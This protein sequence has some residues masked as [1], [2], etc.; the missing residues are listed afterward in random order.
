MILLRITLGSSG[1]RRF[2]KVNFGARLNGD[3]ILWLML[4]SQ[5]NGRR[6]L[7]KM[8]PIKTKLNRLKLIISATMSYQTCTF[9]LVYLKNIFI[10]PS[11]NVALLSANLLLITGFQKSLYVVG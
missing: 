2:A 6:G 1:D 11:L 5:R 7:N 4:P 8:D 9:C 3:E 10:N